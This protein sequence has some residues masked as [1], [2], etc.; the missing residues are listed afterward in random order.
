MKKKNKE[1]LSYLL[2]FLTLAG[3]AFYN[4]PNTN[5]KTKDRVKLGYVEWD[6]E[7]ASTYVMKNILE[8]QGYRVVVTPLDNAIM[9]NAV[10]NGDI[11]AT[12]S[13]WLPNTH[14][15]QYKDYKDQV[16]DLGASLTGARVGLVVP[17][18]M[19]VNSISDLTTQANQTITGVESGAGVVSATEQVL[20]DY[21]NLADWQLVPS[22]SGAMVTALGKAIENG[23]DIIIT[24]W[25][26]HWMFAKYDLKYLQDPKESYG[27]QEEIRT[28]TRK[29]LKTDLPEV[30]HILDNFNWTIEDMEELML[31]I[32]EGQDPNIVAR[33]WVNTHQKQVQSW[34]N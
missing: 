32:S 23:Q 10:R 6:S 4:R 25:S 7:I 11:D 2:I 20:K 33:E 16:V 19:D 18:Y 22:S 28:I 15:E 5:L 31:R 12:L 21:P 30:N 34:I 13:A 27:E 24:G 17:A 8:D 3:I 26:P 14:K 1:L 9:W 29:N